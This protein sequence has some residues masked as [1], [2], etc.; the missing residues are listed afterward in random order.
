MTNPAPSFAVRRNLVICPVGDASYHPAWIGGG[1]RNFDL[2]LIYY[3]GTEGRFSQDAEY[4]LQ[5]GGT[6]S[7]L[8]RIAEGYE[9]WSAQLAQYTAIC[10]PDN[11][12]YTTTKGLNRL[13]ELFH[14]YDL[15]WGHPSIAWPCMHGVL[16][17][18]HNPFTH[19][20][21]VTGTEMLCPVFKRDLFLR[22]LPTFGRNRSAWGIDLLWA[23]MLEHS[24][25]K[26]GILDD[27]VFY[28]L[29]PRRRWGAIASRQLALKDYY[30]VLRGTGVNSMDELNE[31]T[32]T[33]NFGLGDLREIGRQPRS[34]LGALVAVALALARCCRVL[35]TINVLQYARETRKTYL[36]LIRRRPSASRVDCW[37]YDGSRPN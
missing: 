36:R 2:L 16:F 37:G 1:A 33:I 5:S 29:H 3:G 30:E 17:Q 11:D 23:K 13:F 8:E 35:L 31:L 9:A 27:V 4:Y 20:R 14:R 25:S 21:F 12:I 26:I 7:K 6:L 10:L 32:R 24:G 22:L 15:D 28:H 19:I 18:W 34:P